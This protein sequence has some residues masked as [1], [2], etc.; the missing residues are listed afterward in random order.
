MFFVLFAAFISEILFWN[1]ALNKLSQLFIA[2]F[3]I[4]S[5]LLVTFWHYPKK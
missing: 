5:L 3:L 2:S 1:L 4:F